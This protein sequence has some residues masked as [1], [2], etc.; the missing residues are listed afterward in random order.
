MGEWK[1][2]FRRGL[3][4]VLTLAAAGAETASAVS[5]MPPEGITAEEGSLIGISLVDIE[6]AGRN[7]A[8]VSRE[9]TQ[10]VAYASDGKAL[11][12]NDAAIYNA[13][14]T[15]IQEVARGEKTSTEFS[16]RTRLKEEQLAKI[17]VNTIVSYL[18]NDC[19]FDLYWHDKTN[20]DE[21][22]KQTD[23][24]YCKYYGDGRIVFSFKVAQAYRAAPD[25]LYK[26]NGAFTAVNQAKQ[27]AQSIVDTNQNNT[28]YDKLLNYRNAICDLV[29][30]DDVAL[31]DTDYGNSYQLI[32]VFD[33][34]PAS[35]VV[36]EGYA[37]AFKYLCDLSDFDNEIECYTVSG[38]TDAGAGAGE[39]MWNIVRI[40]GKNGE[41][42]LVDVTNCDS[43]TIG[44]PTQLFLT[45]N[46]AGS[47]DTGYTF[48]NGWSS[49]TY[50]YGD[51]TRAIYGSGILSLNNAAH[52]EEAQLHVKGNNTNETAPYSD[53]ET[54][55]TQDSL[56]TGDGQADQPAENSSNQ[57]GG[58]TDATAEPKAGFAFAVTEV[59]KVYGD[60]DFTEPVSG[61]EGS[62]KITYTSS[63]PTV[64][65]VNKRGRVEIK[66]AGTTVIT[67]ENDSKEKAS[68]TL[69]VSPKKLTWDI[70]GL[71]AVDRSDTIE[72][73][74]A[75]LYGEIKLEG[76]LPEDKDRNS[77]FSFGSEYLTGTYS[78]TVPGRQTVTLNWK[79]KEVTLTK[80]SKTGNYEMPEGLPELIGKITTLTRLPDPELEAAEEETG[81]KYKLEMED[82]ISEVSES[83][84]DK[85][86][87]DT[88]PKIE[89]AL[90]SDLS[91]CSGIPEENIAVY[92]VT[93]FWQDKAS[94]VEEDEGE[95]VKVK[96]ENFPEEGLTI[97]LPYPGGMPRDVDD[98]VISHMFV[99]DMYT[100]S[101]GE[102]EHP[103]VIEET[104]DGIKFTVNGLSPI[105]VGWRS[106]EGVEGQDI[107]SPVNI[108]SP[109]QTPQ[110]TPNSGTGQQNNNQNGSGK[111]PVTGDTMQI[112][113][114]A[115]LIGLC[116]ATIKGIQAV[117]RGSKKKS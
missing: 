35:N 8:A 50:Q 24:V 6:D 40:G 10:A 66:N 100:S 96:D 90:K 64:A 62:K 74:K 81:L 98:I 33:D 77:Q 82:G 52:D 68:Y 39:H 18:L 21:N 87:L 59:N 23:G 56:P 65:D 109:T 111:S 58:G 106:A 117:R 49:I 53:E 27:K 37:K 105:A 48:N 42:Y 88:P 76:I 79:E 17:D 16:L 43:G 94:D 67:A 7:A 97:T 1:S 28:D 54:P 11:K 104:V 15:C 38:T 75:T 55:V 31:W 112:L 91:E 92:D 26:V 14:K 19:P 61:Y 30:Y 41:S 13:L 113:I 108:E 51:D 12:S 102:M 4:V 25:E 115:V 5:W 72:D 44:E 29:Y 85:K 32:S 71:Y 110:N 9:Q 69:T 78:E 63:D 83:L 57:Q 2:R 73:K 34:D 3:V 22:G 95:W 80:S 114:Y 47:V 103:M 45:D 89:A 70:S 116:A 107:S 36:C 101:P 84:K 86:E 46:L 60:E 20:T 99:E 93:L